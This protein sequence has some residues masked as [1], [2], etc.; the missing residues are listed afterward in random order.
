MK[1]L[2]HCHPM[3]WSSVGSLWQ[4]HVICSNYF[5]VLTHHSSV[6]AHRDC[7]PRSC[8]NTGRKWFPTPTDQFLNR[9]RERGR[10]TAE[11]VA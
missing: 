6:T 4:A 11:T 10:I 7:R 5:H 2:R 9:K 3:Y 8:S 1:K